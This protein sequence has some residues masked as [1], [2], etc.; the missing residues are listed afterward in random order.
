MPLWKPLVY[1]AAAVTSFTLWSLA[2]VPS[3]AAPLI[4]EVLASNSIG[5]EDADAN[6]PDWIEIH[7]PDETAIALS[8]YF[9]SDDEEVLAKWAFPGGTVIDAGGRL[10]VFASGQELDGSV[11]SDGNLHAN[12][13][14]ASTGEFLALIEPDGTT[15]V[16]SFAP[17]YPRQYQ[18]IAYSQGGYHKVPTPG[19]PNDTESLVEGFVADTTFSVDRGFYTEAVSI[20]LGSTTA[21]AEIFFTTDGTDPSPENGTQYTLPVEIATTTVLRVRGYRDGWEP[22]NVDTQS[23]IFLQDV[24]RQEQDPEG[25]PTTWGGVRADYEMD[26]EVVNDPDYK[27]DFIKAFTRVPTLSLVTAPDNLFHRTTGI[28]QRPTSAGDRWERPVSA[29]L[30]SPDGSEPGFHANCGIRIQGGSSR[31]TDIP[32]HAFSLRFREEYGLGK[33]RYPLLK[34]APFGESAVEEF[35]V[36]QL[37]GTFNHSWF[38]RHYYQCRVAQY[39]RDQ[40]VNDLFL[41]M[42]NPGSR[43][44]WV[45]LYLNGIYWGIYHIHERPDGPY[46]AAYFGGTR[47]DYDVINSGTAVD[48]R[49]TEWSRLNSMANRST[50]S[51]PEGYA[52]IREILDVDNLIDYMLLN[53][54]VGNW[55][56]DGHNWRSGRKRADGEKWIFFPWDSEFAIAPN[57][58]GVISNPKFIDGALNIDRTTVSG[59][60]RPSG[61]H[62]RLTRNP[63]YRLRFADRIQ[64]HMFNAGVLTP[65]HARSVWK[66]RSDLMDDLVI[67][68][69]ARWGDY[70]RDLV[71]GRWSK[72]QY[73]LYTKKD[74]YLPVQEYILNTYITERTEIVF[75]QLE[76]RK[77][78]PDVEAP[79]LMV[80]DVAQHGGEVAAGSMLSIGIP[81]ESGIILYTLDGTDPRGNPPEIV[82]EEILPESAAL[83]VWIP[84]GP[85]ADASSPNWTELGYD[86]AEWVKGAGGV[87]FDRGGDFQPHFGVDLIDTMWTNRAAAYVRIPFPVPDPAKFSELI[88]QLKYEDGFVA[89]LNG[90]EV[91]RANAPDDA[92]WESVATKVHRDDDAVVYEDFSVRNTADLLRAGGNVLAIRGLNTSAGGSDFLA[93]ARMDGKFLVTGEGGLVFDGS[94]VPLNSGAVTVSARVLDGEDFSA[95]TQATYIVGSV[96]AATGSLVV[97]ELHYHPAAGRDDEFVELLNISDVSINLAGVNFSSGIEFRIGEAVVL[98]PGERLVIVSNRQSFEE[99]YAD[100]LSQIR[101]AGEYKRSLSNSGE[102]IVLQDAAV[103]EIAKF[104]YDDSAPWPIEAD[105]LGASLVFAGTD[106]ANPKHWKA[107]A[108]SGGTPGAGPAAGGDS[109]DVWMTTHGFSDPIDDPDGDGLSNILTYYS[110]ADLNGATAPVS[111]RNDGAIVLQRRIGVSG[112]TGMLES[113]D[114]LRTWS[115]VPAGM[116]GDPLSEGNGTE[117]L[118][119]NLELDGVTAK[120]L[121]LRVAR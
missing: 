35:D 75:K 91:A 121:R 104:T 107:S 72:S 97:S 73:Q 12:F 118:R 54:Y 4:S 36:L 114:D 29:E 18:D 56:W 62:S 106:P 90:T 98:D 94:P 108:V 26:P 21:N 87:G 66:R 7:N 64:K 86:D 120:Y 20:K 95:L 39:N 96:P 93:A 1:V 82:I 15:V 88:L 67:A 77:L 74:P 45:H 6:T 50:I 37:R 2:T 111:I 53:F 69:S 32:K 43:G 27:D 76:R 59:S 81:G 110:G 47:D 38:H 116:L 33:L 85:A 63:E 48:G 79:V 25:Y 61:V 117:S 41:E 80:G 34:D 83:S 58:A 103:A 68:E 42:G 55:D 84:A 30:I 17:A 19:K 57:S 71:P 49:T 8:G 14:L 24:L 40:W 115:A 119:V 89:Y 51:T 78:Y 23:Y 10:L 52:E 102:E 46:M 70:K 105:D 101:I 11:D 31:Q 16:Q 112:V 100:R 3:F 28:Y 22:T 60:N 92:D 13:S 109:F 113:S 5:L 65:D 44:R 9:L 99:T